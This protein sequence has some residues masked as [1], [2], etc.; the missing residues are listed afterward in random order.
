MGIPGTQS[1][2]RSRTRVTNYREIGHSGS[3]FSYDT[4]LQTTITLYWQSGLIIP[5][6]VI[7]YILTLLSTKRRDMHEQVKKHE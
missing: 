3:P 2:G 7:E 4:R 6:S 1:H 5:L